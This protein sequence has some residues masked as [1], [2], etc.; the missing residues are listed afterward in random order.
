MPQAIIELRHISKSFPGIL[1]ND[2][3]SLTINQGEI[4]AILGE[5][6]AGK[7]TLASILFGM[8]SPDA[9]EIWLRG[10][11]TNIT[12]PAR[13]VELDIGMVHQ[14][15]KLISEYSVTENIILGDEPLRRLA[16]IAG[17]DR[18]AAGTRIQELIDC[19]QFDL[20]PDALIEDIG[21]SSQQ[22][23]EILKMLYR[24][25]E[26]LIFDE[27]TAMLTPQE[28]ERLLAIIRRLRDNG[29]TIILITHKLEEI[30]LVADRCAI[31]NHGRLIEVFD[32]ASTSTQTMA[33]RMVGYELNLNIKKTPPNFGRPVLEVSDLTVY[34]AL[35]VKRVDAVSLKVHAGEVFALAGV[36]G[37]GQMELA[38]AIAG[39]MDVHSGS[40]RLKGEEITKTTARR[41]ACAGIAY[42]P[43]DRQQV[44]LILDFTVSENLMSKSYFRPPYCKGPFLQTKA[45]AR[46]A[47]D[48]CQRYDIRSAQGVATL[49]R[50]L[51]GGNQQK[52]IVAREIEAQGDL[53][54]FVQPTR[55]LDI[56]ATLGIR[57]RIIAERDKGRAVLLISLE[58]E[59]VK[60][61][62]DTIGVIYNGRIAHTAPASEVGMKE[63]GEYMLGVRK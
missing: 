13:A 35:K 31:L 47:E 57:Q 4:F 42:I 38:D 33:N 36:A 52:L 9:G 7:S 12:S 50:S 16:G 20:A 40:I 19:Y 45:A 10:K 23:V 3:I 48:I 8:Y 27:P 22:R 63:L 37:N 61:L 56:G 46:L 44:G 34:D 58:L 53:V 51:S 6:G 11:K 39:L 21:V 29:K 2:D 5:N 18:K 60:A 59:E 14:H 30:K 1:A 17:L 62:A 28:T 54:I 15:F 43:E 26:I 55:G 41:R 24:S 32:V 25:A 49:V